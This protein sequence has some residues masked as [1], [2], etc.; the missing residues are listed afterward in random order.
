M[1][2]VIVGTGKVA[3][4]NYI[5]TFLKEADVSLT[6]FSRTYPRAVALGERFGIRIARTLEELFERRPEAVFVLTR[7]EQRLEATRSLLPFKPRRLFLEKPLVAAEGQAHVSQQDFWDG[8]ALLQEAEAAG[9][10]AAMVFNYRFFDQIQRARQLIQEREFGSAVSVAAFSHFACWSHCIDLILEFVGPVQ[11]ISAL[12]GGQLRPFFET[13]VADVA[14]SFL[15]GDQAA[16]TL[17][18]TSG[19]NWD[20]PLLELIFNFEGGRIHLRDLDQD[21]EVLDYRGN[22]HEL[23]SPLRAGSRW[24]KYDESFA[25]SIRAYLESIREGKPPPVPGR[26]GLRELQFEASVVKSIAECRPVVPDR[27]FPLNPES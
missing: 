6:C 4:D 22:V 2:I 16:G 15:I 23:F 10:E 24:R 9:A 8:K 11:E 12:R 25:K 19:T 1:E 27:E 17:V 20:F 26:A 18:G 13:Q 7:E 5:P 14:I 3:E 21:M